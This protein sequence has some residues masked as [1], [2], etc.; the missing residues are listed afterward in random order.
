MIQTMVHTLWGQGC[1]IFIEINVNER[2]SNP[3]T[4][5]VCSIQ[6]CT[7]HSTYSALQNHFKVWFQKCLHHF[8]TTA[9]IIR[10][11][12]SYHTHD[13]GYIRI[14]FCPLGRCLEIKSNQ[15]KSKKKSIERDRE[16][17]SENPRKRKR[18][19]RWKERYRFSI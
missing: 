12:W 6:R 7:L 5:K 18:I 14:S 11:K 4:I 1:F 15:I 13:P 16:K 2:Q 9:R 8:G 3:P 19:K 10:V 17:K